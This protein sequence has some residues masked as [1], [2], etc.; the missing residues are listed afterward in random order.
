MITNAY[1]E[2]GEYCHSLVITTDDGWTHYN[3]IHATGV[4]PPPIDPNSLK[5][6]QMLWVLKK[7]SGQDAGE[8]PR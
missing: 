6:R 7:M 8:F 2:L 5:G 4:E 3:N 1:I